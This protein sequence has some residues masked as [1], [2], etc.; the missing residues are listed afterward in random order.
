MSRTFREAATS[1]AHW[2]NLF[3]RDILA[4]QEVN[5]TSHVI[6]PNCPDAISGPEH[7]AGA[8][9][10]Q[11]PTIS[12]KP[13][14][15][16]PS[17]SEPSSS[18]AQASPDGL[19]P[20]LFYSMYM[21][22]AHRKR[23]CRG[24][25][26]QV[27]GEALLKR[28][29]IERAVVGRC[30]CDIF[31]HMIFLGL[32][33]PLFFVSLLLLGQ[34]LDDKVPEW[35]VDAVGDASWLLVLLPAAVGFVLLALS[36]CT[37]TCLTH[38]QCTVRAT[39]AELELYMNKRVACPCFRRRMCCCLQCDEWKDHFVA[40][41]TSESELSDHV[42]DSSPWS[43]PF[44]LS[45]G[46]IP[47]VAAG[48]LLLLGA[49]AAAE[50]ASDDVEASALNGTSWM[51]M[52]I[53]GCIFMCCFWCFMGAVAGLDDA[54]EVFIGSM[55]CC[56]LPLTCTFMAVGHL[57]DLAGESGD[58]ERFDAHLAYIPMYI[59]VGCAGLVVILGFAKFVF[60]KDADELCDDED[61][62]MAGCGACAAAAVLI[63]QV[64]L[65]ADACQAGGPQLV[66]SYTAAL[67]PALFIACALGI[68]GFVSSAM[69][70]N[71]RKG[72]SNPYLG[73]NPAH[74]N[75]PVQCCWGACAH[76]ATHPHTEVG[77]LY[78]T[79]T[80]AVESDAFSALLSSTY[81]SGQ[82]PAQFRSAS[83]EGMQQ[84]LRIEH[85][86]AT[87]TVGGSLLADPAD[88][89]RRAGVSE[90]DLDLWAPG[91]S[92]ANPG[93]GQAGSAAAGGAAAP[94]SNTGVQQLDP[95]SLNELPLAGD[96]LRVIQEALAEVLQENQ[97]IM[98][99]L[100]EF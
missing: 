17:Q 14:T 68:L 21:E 25:A 66:G 34:K 10:N 42:N 27:E 95:E 91:S 35:Q 97:Q 22:V 79:Q 65:L 57:W 86:S 18:V 90:S 26:A 82:V 84:L 98:D 92:A 16:A 4:A 77:K 1:N 15:E 70:Y 13:R 29:F 20:R 37:M 69:M 80:G 33:F 75:G 39:D 94:V 32:P 24:K 45:L 2:Q 58:D 93:P 96:R 46:I 63:T 50:Y 5:S 54:K 55:C 49:K 56:I 72:T 52:F 60:E 11:S 81:N 12:G 73:W 3:I 59:V 6:Q 88:F 7:G 61:D 64:V 76:Y 43:I 30:I 100:E 44:R 28:R 41:V 51:V 87:N 36:Y 31:Q 40:E 99:E 38:P 62:C 53:P 78:A 47:F 74:K 23:N 67:G 9:A 8:A 71:S 83:K 48:G 89:L 85:R 19:P